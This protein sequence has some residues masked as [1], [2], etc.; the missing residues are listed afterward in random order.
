M[1]SFV[2][3]DDVYFAYGTIFTDKTKVVLFTRNYQVL[4]IEPIEK[5]TV[6]IHQMLQE[7]KLNPL[8][9]NKIYSDRFVSQ[10][11]SYLSPVSVMD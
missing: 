10:V 5:C 4:K 11:L 2:H 6:A 3:E 8:G 9:G 1:G 7:D